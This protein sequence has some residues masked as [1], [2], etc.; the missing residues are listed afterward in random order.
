ML[1][2]DPFKYFSKL[3]ANMQILNVVS[4]KIEFMPRRILC[5]LLA[6]V[7]SREKYLEIILRC[8]FKNSVCVFLNSIQIFGNFL[9]KVPS[10]TCALRDR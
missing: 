3:F 2:F 10:A 7:S 9:K 5:K 8:Y 6:T 4:A 1:T